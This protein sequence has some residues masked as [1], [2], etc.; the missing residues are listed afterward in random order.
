MP[1][2]DELARIIYYV[3][4]AQSDHVITRICPANGGSNLGFVSVS[5]SRK[6]PVIVY[7]DP[8]LSMS[9]NLSLENAR[10]SLRSDKLAIPWRK[11]HLQRVCALSIHSKIPTRERICS[12]HN[13]LMR[14]P[15]G[16]ARRMYLCAKYLERGK[17]NLIRLSH[18]VQEAERYGEGYICLQSARQC[19]RN[20]SQWRE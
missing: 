5:S 11:P 7:S 6:C 20:Q 15:R 18:V 14:T 19:D 9:S 8:I 10:H 2:M 4:A 1:L 16:C 12:T 17:E 13:G 3:L